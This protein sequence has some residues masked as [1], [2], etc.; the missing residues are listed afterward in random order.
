LPHLH[1][2]MENSSQMSEPHCES[3]LCINSPAICGIPFTQIS[4]VIKSLDQC[5][6]VTT[7]YHVWIQ[8]GIS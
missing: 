8:I 5:C 4:M 7:N 3:N 2:A 1:E 6:Q